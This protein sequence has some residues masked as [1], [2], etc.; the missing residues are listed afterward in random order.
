MIFKR[1]FPVTRRT[2]RQWINT[3]VRVLTPSAHMDALGVNLSEGG[4]CLFSV[5]NLSVGSHIDI[6]FVPRRGH[7]PVRVSGKIRHRALY[8]YG[9]EF[10]SEVR[11]D[12]GVTSPPLLQRSSQ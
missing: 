5:A 2:Q 1:S 6:E 8:L 10:M 4:M 7:E 11:S 12:S 9:I 3:T